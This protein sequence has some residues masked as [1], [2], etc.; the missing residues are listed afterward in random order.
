MNRRKSEK[1]E[2]NPTLLGKATYDFII[3]KCKPPKLSRCEFM[4]LLVIARQ[5]VGRRDSEDHEAP[6]ERDWLAMSQLRERTGYARTSLSNAQETLSKD[7]FIFITIA[8]EHFM[9]EQRVTLDNPKLRKLYGAKYQEKARFHYSLTPRFLG[10][11]KKAL[12]VSLSKS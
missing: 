10:I 8:D 9:K 12:E 11:V 3:D 5:T 4:L 1:I 6:K 2:I 7:G